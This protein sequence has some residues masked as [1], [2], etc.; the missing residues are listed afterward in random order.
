[1]A[2]A[3]S[4]DCDL[5][6]VTDSYGF[7]NILLGYRFCV[8]GFSRC[9]EELSLIQLLDW[10]ELNTELHRTTPHYTALHLFQACEPFADH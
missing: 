1:M 2:E 10:T 6:T 9:A 7:T 3:K 5:L 4:L 8:T